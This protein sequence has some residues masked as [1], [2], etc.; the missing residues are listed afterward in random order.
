MQ[1]VKI[2]KAVESDTG[3]L[4]NEINAWIRESGVRVVSVTGNIAP[5]SE[6][7]GSSA[8]ALGQGR[9]ASSDVV[10]IVLYETGE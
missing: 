1:Q 2:F 10:L 8:S 7:S 9:F 4:E 5:Q 6:A 3:S